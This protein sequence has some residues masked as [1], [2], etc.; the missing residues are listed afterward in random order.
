[1]T[2]RD[3]IA[4]GRAKL[5][6]FH[7]CPSSGR[8][9]ELA[10]WA[11]INLPALLDKIGWLR[12]WKAG[13]EL[14][15]AE[16]KRYIDEANSGELVRR[17][18]AERDEARQAIEVMQT[19][20]ESQLTRMAKER[21]RLQRKVD[22]LEA[23]QRPPLGYEDFAATINQQA[24]RIAKLERERDAANLTLDRVADELGCSRDQLDLWSARRIVVERDNARDRVAEL[25]TALAEANDARMR[26]LD[27]NERLRARIAELEA[28]QRPPLGYVVARERGNE[29]SFHRGFYGSIAAAL[30]AVGAHPA[31]RG[32]R[33]FVAEIREVQP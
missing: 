27:V 30:D 5:D 2:D 8:A 20:H 17:L 4:E 9:F 13:A 10:E 31:P 29:T 19:A 25:T 22:R 26:H 28:G 33:N 14:T 18:A 6:A 3:L 12:V 16:D 11:G 15:L 7:A 24:D 1:M 23:A 21:A 32:V